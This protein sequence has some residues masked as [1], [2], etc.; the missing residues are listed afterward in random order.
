MTTFFSLARATREGC[1][2]RQ[3]FRAKSLNTYHRIRAIP[4]EFR[5]Y[6]IR[7]ILLRWDLSSDLKR[8]CSSV[9]RRAWWLVDAD[10]AVP[11]AN[12]RTSRASILRI[13]T[14]VIVSNYV[15]MFTRCWSSIAGIDITYSWQ[16]L[17]QNPRKKQLRNPT[18]GVFL[19]NKY[20]S[21]VGSLL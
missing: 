7:E 19:V 18:Y 15:L 16:S 8:N 11:K 2:L 6:V 13:G 4:Y 5:R 21:L 1:C 9:T 3:I 17:L 20:I 12:T 10:L 14:L